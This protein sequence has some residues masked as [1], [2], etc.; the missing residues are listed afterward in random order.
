MELTYD[1]A[2]LFLGI[3]GQRTKSK[4]SQRYLHTHVHS[5]PIHNSQK[6]KAAQVS[7][8]G[9]WINTT[10]SIQ[11]MEYYLAIKRSSDTCYNVDEPSKHYTK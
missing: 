4:D 6:V 2:I 3:Y 9:G 10:W 11:I 1:Q 8:G 5:S 7:I